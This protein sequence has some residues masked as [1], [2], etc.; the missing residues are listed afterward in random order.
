MRP[1]RSFI[2]FGLS[3]SL[4]L[5]CGTQERA[6]SREATDSVRPATVDDPS[7][8][9][10]DT[11]GSEDSVIASDTA[12]FFIPPGP[13]LRPF[14]AEAAGMGT[15]V[16]AAAPLR[17]GAHTVI[18]SGGPGCKTPTKQEME[19]YDKFGAQHFCFTYAMEANST[20][21]T[22]LTDAVYR[23]IGAVVP[24]LDLIDLYQPNQNVL[25]FQVKKDA[26]YRLYTYWAHDLG[27]VPP[28]GRY[29]DH[30]FVNP[31]DRSV[32]YYLKIR[33]RSG[34]NT[35]IRGVAEVIF[36][37]QELCEKARSERFFDGIGTS[38]PCPQ[39]PTSSL[40]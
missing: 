29:T 4:A 32:D 16:L 10:V 19:V 22:L 17:K 26:N 39:P 12:E 21:H 31:M 35:R 14:A 15:R 36:V 6:S 3:A 11:A 13:T 1:H 28:P 9:Q 37:P 5:G 7:A 24:G 27:N 20:W 40:P 2:A 23:A 38:R 30:K 18:N 33:K 25:R 8:T 34:R